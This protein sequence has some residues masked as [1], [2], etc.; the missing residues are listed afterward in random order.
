[1]ERVRTASKTWHPR[2]RNVVVVAVGYRCR[3]RSRERRSKRPQ[4]ARTLTIQNAP[5]RPPTHQP[6]DR[7]IQTRCP[8]SAPCR[9]CVT[10]SEKPL[11]PRPPSPGSRQDTA[12]TRPSHTNKSEE[13][14]SL[15]HRRLVLP[16]LSVLPSLPV[17]A[18]PPSHPAR[19]KP[20]P[21]SPLPI[22]AKA[23]A[24]KRE[25][26]DRPETGD[27]GEV[28]FDPLEPFFILHSANTRSQGTSNQQ[29]HI[30]DGFLWF[31]ARRH[32]PYCR[33]THQH[34]SFSASNLKCKSRKNDQ[35]S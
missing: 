2:E 30:V 28:D 13:L 32:Q 3:I 25:T 18:L 33:S 12:K 21:R 24:V 31:V 4:R 17:S 19:C 1:M 22:E 9:C 26:Q 6:K 15:R 10:V 23:R 35:F 34:Q 29:P 8:L 5:Q 11:P 16:K 14:D 7:R 20:L 27:P